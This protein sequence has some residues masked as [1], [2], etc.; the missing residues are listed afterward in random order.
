MTLDAG[1]WYS[2][3]LFDQLGADH[4]TKSVPQMEFF[5]DAG[6]DGII[7]GNHDFDRY[8]SALFAML[9]KANDMKLN[10][11]VIVSNL[12][13]PLPEKSKFKLFY[14]TSSTVHFIPYLIKETANTRVGVLGYITPD[15]L[16]VSNDYRENLQFI[17]YSFPEGNKYEDLIQL[18][19]EQ[20]SMLKNELNCDL[21]VVIIHGGNLD[22]ED[23][24]LLNLPDVD[25]VFGGHTHESYFY[26][27]P[28]SSV[29]SQCGYS[30]MQLTA[31]SVGVDPENELIF[32]DGNEEF[33]RLSQTPQ[34]IHVTNKAD[35]DSSF[36]MKVSSW[37][38]E[39]TSL[40]NYNL[41]EIIFQGNL[42]QMFPPQASKEVNAINFAH[43][44]VDEFNK[45]EQKNV[46]DI[47]DPVTV[48]FWNKDFMLHD[49]IAN[50]DLSD[51]SL[52][53]DDAY[54]LIFFPAH[55]DL[56]T[57][58]VR[59]E[60]IYYMLQGMF[61]LNKLVSPLLTVEPGG[62]LYD[63]SRYFGA[64][65]LISN[66]RTIDNIPYKSWPPFVRMLTNSVTAPYFWKLE[67]FSHGFLNN[68]PRDK[69]GNNIIQEDAH[70]LNYPNELELFLNYLRSISVINKK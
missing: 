62:I 26:A 6:Y 46:P 31:L 50:R 18:A 68:I 44:L 23:V 3:S 16:F 37:K 65:P 57:F 39:L 47:S 19:A 7:L 21:V 10:I 52:T 9:E 28:F 29:T 64:I 49:L 41:D 4:R 12:I 17:G 61:V 32:R 13:S 11:N 66:L 43:M 20:S 45:W 40:Y 30:G 35:Q 34:C 55:K 54:S 22:K 36:E 1:D 58:Y 25:V 60:D 2:G 8:E 48:T 27:S 15:A 53:F 67:Q 69:T 38:E 14:D 5:H 70:L 63:E 51:V 24:G 59:K 33:D 56:Y 42:S